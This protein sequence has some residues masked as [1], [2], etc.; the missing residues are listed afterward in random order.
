MVFG[1]TWSDHP[2]RHWSYPVRVNSEEGSGLIMHAPITGGGEIITGHRHGSGQGQKELGITTAVLFIRAIST[3]S[4]FPWIAAA[5]A[6]LPRCL[7]GSNGPMS[8]DSCSAP[9]CHAG[10]Q[11]ESRPITTEGSTRSSANPCSNAEM[12]QSTRLITGEKMIKPIM[13]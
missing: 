12:C 2:W 4:G 5:P 13:R 6:D 7:R 9:A 8:W 3:S 11:P 1:L 10:P